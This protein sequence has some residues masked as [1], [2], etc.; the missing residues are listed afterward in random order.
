MWVFCLDVCLYTMCVSGVLRG[1]PHRTGVTNGYEV[2][3]EFWEPNLSP[4][5]TTYNRHRKGC[6]FRFIFI[7]IHV[8]LQMFGQLPAA[9]RG[10]GVL[11]PRIL[12]LLAVVS[13]WQGC[14]EPNLV[15][16]EEEEVL[17]N[18]WTI[19]PNL[20][21]VSYEELFREDQPV[22]IVLVVNWCRKAQPIV[23]AIIP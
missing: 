4:L 15:L 7:F 13:T 9:G 6:C 23:G 17:L 1:R 20:I 18:Y 3:C 11:I 22:E 10:A 19:S 8:C 16:P 2:P 14:W 12:A 21:R 5:D